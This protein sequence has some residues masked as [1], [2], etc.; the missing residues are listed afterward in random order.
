M[1]VSI[2]SKATW[3]GVSATGTA[4]IVDRALGGELHGVGRQVEQDLAQAHRIA[5]ASVSSPGSQ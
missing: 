1:P 4:R 5:A 3:S 2:T